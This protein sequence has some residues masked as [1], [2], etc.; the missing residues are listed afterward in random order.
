M[1]VEHTLIAL[2]SSGFLQRGTRFILPFQKHF[3]LFRGLSALESA[4]HSIPNRQKAS[5]T[6]C[7]PENRA[8]NRGPSFTKYPG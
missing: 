7:K 2:Q 5:R 3:V 6:A 8:V 4:K 1:P